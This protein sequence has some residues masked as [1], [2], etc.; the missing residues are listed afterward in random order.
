MSCIV[1][2]CPL[3]LRVTA[4]HADPRDAAGPPTQIALCRLLSGPDRYTG[5][6]V[7]FRA[8]YESDGLEFWTLYDPTCMYLGGIMPSA[9]VYDSVVGKPL[10]E[11]LHHG[12]AGTTDKEIEATWT[13]IFHWDPRNTP[14]TGKVPRWLEV[15]QIDGLISRPK[16][17]PP[18]P[19]PTVDLTGAW[20]V[21]EVV[22][23]GPVGAH[24]LTESDPSYLGARLNIGLERWTWERLGRTGKRL[25]DRCDL[26]VVS[27]LTDEYF[28]LS[29]KKTSPFGLRNPMLLTF[30]EDGRFA[31]PWYGDAF[32]VMKRVQASPR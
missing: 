15:T 3:L 6:R 28:D 26:P 23:A 16:P 8:R 30:M 21:V 32:L 20:E 4:L 9:G 7:K 13:G 22:V 29:C 11:A 31:I 18:P 19:R 2:V 25:D 24:A 14:G 10:A 12:F 17:F 27:P 5:R 1:L